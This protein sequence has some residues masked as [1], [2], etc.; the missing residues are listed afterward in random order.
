MD[1]L[2]KPRPQGLTTLPF[3]SCHMKDNVEV[4]HFHTKGRG[5][6]GHAFVKITFEKCTANSYF[7]NDEVGIKTT[8]ANL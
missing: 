1:P 3:I 6:Q 4:I 2:E 5:V 8:F 7:E